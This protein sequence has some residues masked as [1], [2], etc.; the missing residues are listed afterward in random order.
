MAEKGE[1][2]AEAEEEADRH[3]D[4]EELRRQTRMRRVK[5]AAR[6]KAEEDNRDLPQ[7]HAEEDREDRL[8]AA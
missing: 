5:I 2:N 6:A 8:G 3:R 7:C 4:A 1:D